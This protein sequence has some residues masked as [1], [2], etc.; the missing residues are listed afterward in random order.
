MK[1]TLKFVM[2]ECFFQISADILQ[3]PQF[4]VIL[5]VI[6]EIG[7]LISLLCCYEKWLFMDIVDQ[8]HRPSIHEHDVFFIMTKK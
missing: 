6:E 3:F 1:P 4:F 5:I 8:Q 2:L 7:F